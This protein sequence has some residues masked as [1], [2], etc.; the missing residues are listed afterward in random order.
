MDS[1]MSEQRT[2]CARFK[3][4][5]T[6]LR[7]VV[8]MDET[9]VH[10]FKSETKQQTK[11]WRH[12]GSPTLKTLHAQICWRSSCFGFLVWPRSHF[13]NKDRII[14]ENYCLTLL[15]IL[16]EKI[17]REDRYNG[18]LFLQDNAPNC[19]LPCK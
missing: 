19:T 9:W 13:L 15:N 1:Q 16:R 6:F 12:S 18:M 3:K 2:L 8:N 11:D 14:T 10:F 17:Y 4:D 7:L 5:A